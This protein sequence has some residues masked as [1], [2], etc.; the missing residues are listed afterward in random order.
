MWKFTS[1]DYKKVGATLN[2]VDVVTI[3]ITLKQKGYCSLETNIKMLCQPSKKS[4][5]CS[6][7]LQGAYETRKEIWFGLVHS[8]KASFWAH[9]LITN[10]SQP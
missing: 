9:A 10:M 3:G 2:I 8:K 7:N 4:V 1:N 6:Y 5:C